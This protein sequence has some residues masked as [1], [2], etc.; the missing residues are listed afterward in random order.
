MHLSII[1]NVVAM[2]YALAS[3]V[4][5]NRRQEP[6][7]VPL[8]LTD[9]K[10]RIADSYIVILK[11]GTNFDEHLARVEQDLRTTADQFHYMDA[12]NAYS[13]TMKGSVQ[14]MQ[15]KIRTDSSVEAVQENG[16]VP[17]DEAFQVLPGPSTDP[18]DIY[19]LEERETGSDE[20][21]RNLTSRQTA[22]VR[23]WE[24]KTEQNKIWHMAMVQGDGR[25]KNLNTN[26]ETNNYDHI[27]NPDNGAGVNI[28][29]IDSGIRSTHKEF[30]GRVRH[31]G[32]GQDNDPSP[33]CPGEP[34]VSTG[35][36]LQRPHE[37]LCEGR[38]TTLPCNN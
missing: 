5:H 30:G 11:T 9:D 17:L 35:S 26:E 7:L 29:I 25:L 3:V 14:I 33:Y 15:D 21:P 32:G 12:I 4:P 28:Y 22:N 19:Y 1:L 23:G 10:Y 16:Q 6:S 27:T 24:K 13:F 2:R 8:S 37:F 38:L 20:T 36:T 34:N 31:L 18:A